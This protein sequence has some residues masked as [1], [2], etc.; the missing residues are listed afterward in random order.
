MWVLSE[1]RSALTISVMYPKRV[2]TKASMR[3]KPSLRKGLS[4]VAFQAWSRRSETTKA[5]AG[6]GRNLSAAGGTGAADDER[7]ALGFANRLTSSIVSQRPTTPQF[8]TR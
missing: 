6:T 2:K 4:R 3:K 5:A 8:R 7:R 1:L